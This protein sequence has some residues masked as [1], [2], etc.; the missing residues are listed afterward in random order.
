MDGILP[1]NVEQRRTNRSPSLNGPINPF[2]RFV[3]ER[4][5]DVDSHCGHVMIGS[6]GGTNINDKQ[7]QN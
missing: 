1:P 6:S 7:L 3:S 4:S 2:K 5:L